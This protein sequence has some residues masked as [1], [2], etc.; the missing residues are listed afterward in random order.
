MSHIPSTFAPLNEGWTLT[1][2]NP[3]AAPEALRATLAAGIPATVPGEATLDLLNAGLI[4]DP[5]DG[6]NEN[7][8]QWIG[9]VD[10]RFT[11]RF[12]WQD[13][14]SDRHD[15]VA[16]GLDTIADIA[17]NGRPVASTRN[18]HRSYRWD[19]RGL[20]RDGANELTVTFTS[21]LKNSWAAA[22]LIL[23]ANASRASQAESLPRG[24]ELLGRSD[25]SRRWQ[26]FALT[27]APLA[28]VPVPG[29]LGYGPALRVTVG[30]RLAQPVASMAEDAALEGGLA[31]TVAQPPG[32]KARITFAGTLPSSG[33]DIAAVYRKG[34]GLGGNL[35]KGRLSMIMTPVPGLSSVVNPLA[36]EGGSDAETG[37]AMR[38]AAPLSI[39][40]LGRAVSLA[41]FT[42]MALSFRGIGKARAD[43]LRIDGRRQVVVTITTTTLDPP[44][45]GSTVAQDLTEALVAAAPPGTSVRLE[46]FTLYLLA[47]TLATLTDPALER[48]AVELA[49]RQA[50]LAKFGRQARPFSLGLHRSEIL[51]A[52]Q[53][54]PGV[55][56][57]RLDALT[58][59][60]LLEDA[61]GRILC[62]PPGQQPSGYRPAGLLALDDSGITLTEMIP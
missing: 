22:D 29:P 59:P 39:A 13:D 5:F 3:E 6:D 38:H 54:V 25:A 50:L 45:P 35:G 4:D 17:L 7:K 18:F 28:F 51:A 15:L 40:T 14:G 32:D 47:I 49:L 30:G 43:E 20:L 41:D 16:Y 56:A 10:W 19:V 48:A 34:G 12:D 1:A 42:A 61:T 23:R 2:V 58:A 21:P 36:A 53:M 44:V 33:Q 60:G 8:Q 37:D 27:T 55:I 11:C 24:P 57:A 31:Y 9:D 62:P 52:A 26:A 46:G